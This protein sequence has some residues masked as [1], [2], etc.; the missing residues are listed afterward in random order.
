MRIRILMITCLSAFALSKSTNGQSVLSASVSKKVESIKPSADSVKEMAETLIK[1]GFTAGDGYGEVWIR[2]LNT[3]LTVACKVNDKDLIKKHLITFF[4]FQQPDGGILDGY[5]PIK[6]GGVS[7]DF[8]HSALAPGYAGHKNTVETDQ[9]TSLV[10]AI[11]KYIRGTGDKTILKDTVAGASVQKHLEQAMEFL[12]TKRFEKKYGLVWGATTVD[13]GD[14]QP[15]HSWGVVLDSNSHRT[16]DIYDNAMFIIAINDFLDMADLSSKSQRYWKD[17]KGSL[18]ANVRKHL[19][20]KTQQKFVPHIYLNGS[21]FPASFNESE[22]YYHGGTAI[23]IEAGL[24]SKE[25]VKAAY[26]KMKENVKKANAATIGLTIYPVYPKGFF[27][28]TGMG[29]YSY[30]NGG[31]WTWFGGRMV[32]QLIRYD[33][34]EEACEAMAPMLDRVIKNKGFYEWYTPDNKP[35]GSSSF[36][37]EAGVLWSAITELEQKTKK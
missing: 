27:K 19:W 17:I 23:A 34:L 22:I 5:I 2:D 28:N 30:Q 26:N 1:K 25:E 8:Y 20:D 11:A 31:D 3:F 6:K 24:L 12:L 15:E 32:S 10:Q 33:L 37:G 4:Q 13:W 14:V 21:P 29:P 35:Q 7:Y 18:A 36:R 16:I 9:E